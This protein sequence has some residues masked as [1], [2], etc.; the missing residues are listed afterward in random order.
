MKLTVFISEGLFDCASW[1]YV[2][3]MLGIQDGMSL[4]K[5]LSYREPYLN[6][7]II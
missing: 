3:R 6:S 2:G 1:E 4:M 5:I 7:W